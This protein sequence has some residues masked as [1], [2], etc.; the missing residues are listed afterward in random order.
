MAV[1]QEA[2]S[3]GPSSAAV[4]A[5]GI[6]A[7][8]FGLVSLIAEVSAGFSTISTGS[9]PWARSRARRPSASYFG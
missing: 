1:K 3:S 8:A 9:S 7:L 2:L 6:G 4:L 5:A